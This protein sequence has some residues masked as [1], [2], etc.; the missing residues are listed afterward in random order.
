MRLKPGDTASTDLTHMLENQQYYSTNKAIYP[1]LANL[2]RW[3]VREPEAKSGSVSLFT[4]LLQVHDD[5]D[6]LRPAPTTLGAVHRW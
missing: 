5:S 2:H 3:I 4:Q 1:G 6:I